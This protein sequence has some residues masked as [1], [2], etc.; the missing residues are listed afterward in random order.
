MELGVRQMSQHNN[1]AIFGGTFD[2]IHF[3]HLLVAEQIYNS[4]SLDRIIFMPA[5][6]PPHKSDRKITS[7]RDRLNML[8]L[9]IKDNNHFLS[10]NYE[11]NKK[12]KSY[13]AD[14]LRFFLEQKF[15]EKVYFIIGADSL[16]DIHNWKDP[17]FLL[18][19]AYF[20]VAPRPNY[21][22]S[23]F[24]E[25]ERYKP[26]RDRILILDTIQV[27]ISSTNIRELVKEKKSI[28]Y[29]TP[30]KVIKYINDNNLYRS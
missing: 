5:G 2:P 14:T 19:N 20:I 16:L 3:G 11:L 21:D 4:F 25:D 24:Y 28:K 12:G 15:L 17:G 10:S 6:Q 1:I 9:A 22:I 7:A 23:R 26:Y 8:N 27:E 30:E 13:T 29:Q 18:E